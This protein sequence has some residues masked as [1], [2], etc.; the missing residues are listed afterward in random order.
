MGAAGRGSGISIF[1]GGAGDGVLGAEKKHM[2]G[3]LLYQDVLVL[4]LEFR[5]QEP[6][7]G[8]SSDID[9][10]IPILPSGIGTALREPFIQGLHK[11]LWDDRKTIIAVPYSHLNTSGSEI[12][13]FNMARLSLSSADEAMALT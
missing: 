12:P 6:D 1:G 4:S 11:C 10:N 2:S 3:F 7:H 8:P 9:P 5:Q 13:F